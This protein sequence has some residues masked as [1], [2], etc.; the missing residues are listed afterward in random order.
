MQSLE[1]AVK[2]YLV[3]DDECSSLSKTQSEYRKLK[4]EL[5]PVIIDH[6]QTN[7]LKT[8]RV[9]SNPGGPR[10]LKLSQRTKK[11]PF[12]KARMMEVLTG[13]DG[14]TLNK[15]IIDSIVK[16]MCETGEPEIVYSLKVVKLKPEVQ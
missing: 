11:P 7:S 10:D 6:L 9:M 14:K 5:N 15:D 2:Q 4:K 8:V 13:V 16:E 3:Y 1:D 12:T